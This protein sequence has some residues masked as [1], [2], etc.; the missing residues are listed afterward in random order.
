MSDKTTSLQTVSD[1]AS[2]EVRLDMCADL[3]QPRRRNIEAHST[4]QLSHPFITSSR[5]APAAGAAAQV[6]TMGPHRVAPCRSNLQLV[7]ATRNASA[8]PIS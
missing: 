6:G 8:S 7:L 3:S 4:A 1:L 5:G 2:D